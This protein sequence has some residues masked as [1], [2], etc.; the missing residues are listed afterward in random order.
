[1]RFDDES[2]TVFQHN[3]ACG[4]MP[5]QPF[6][7]RCYEPEFLSG[8]KFD[9][10][11]AEQIEEA[12]NMIEGPSGL[13]SILSSGLTE[14]EYKNMFDIDSVSNY[15]MGASQVGHWDSAIGNYNNDLVYFNSKTKKWSFVTWDLDN[16]FGRHAQS[17]YLLRDLERQEKPLFEPFFKSTALMGKL[18]SDFKTYLSNLNIDDNGGPLNDKLI[19]ARDCYMGELNNTRPGQ[20][21]TV[22]LTGHEAFLKRLCKNIWSEPSSR[23]ENTVT[24]SESERMNLSKA[25][26]TFRFRK[27]RFLQIQNALRADLP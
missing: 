17:D 12:R 4:F 25:D 11:S 7:V 20:E 8:K 1:M 26:Q 22:A 15:L 3:K 16:T 24:L 18:R 2:P 27:E 13:M 9:E 23:N 5:G 19:E 6:T 14:D 10:E 21:S